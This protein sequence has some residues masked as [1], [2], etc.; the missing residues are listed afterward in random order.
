MISIFLM[1]FLSS[2]HNDNKYDTLSSNTERKINDR[3][4]NLVDKLYEVQKQ[5]EIKR[6][7]QDLMIRGHSNK[8]MFHHKKNHRMKQIN[9]SSKIQNIQSR[10]KHI[11]Q[12]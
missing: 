9:K 11:F 2:V 7:I 10:T 1:F 8:I 3:L 5:R 6:D 4:Q 12:N